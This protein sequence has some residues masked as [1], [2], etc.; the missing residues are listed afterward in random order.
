MHADTN[1][2]GE[3]C[4]QCGRLEDEV[5]RLSE[6]LK[7]VRVML[8]D[9]SGAPDHMTHCDRTMGATHPCTC[10]ANEIRKLLSASTAPLENDH[11]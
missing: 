11:G 5:E 7:R 10:G 3:S 9:V 8:Y 1:I 6:K 2:E 4:R